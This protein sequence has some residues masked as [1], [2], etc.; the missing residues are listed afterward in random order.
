MHAVND[1]I[2]MHVDNMHTMTEQITAGIEH[3]SDGKEREL[4]TTHVVMENLM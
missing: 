2:C 1:R 4:V 3:T